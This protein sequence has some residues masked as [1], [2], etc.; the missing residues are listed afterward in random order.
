MLGAVHNCPYRNWNNVAERVMST[1]NLGLQNVALC[2][3]AMPEEFEKAV[4][5]KDVEIRGVVNKTPHL[6]AQLLDSMAQP[7][8]LFK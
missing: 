6:E 2:R 8:I 7:I 1:L 5:G 3:K 4:A